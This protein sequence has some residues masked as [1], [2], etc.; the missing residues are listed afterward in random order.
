MKLLGNLVTLESIKAVILS[1]M[2]CWKCLSSSQTGRLCGNGIF[3][4]KNV[5]RVCLRKIQDVAVT[6]QRIVVRF[7]FTNG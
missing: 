6:R 1:A 7:S 5:P 4:D 3:G 2:L